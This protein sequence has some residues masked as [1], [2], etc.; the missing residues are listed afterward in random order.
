MKKVKNIMDDFDYNNPF[1]TNIPKNPIINLSKRAGIIR[2]TKELAFI[3]RDIAYAFFLESF[4]IK[5]C[6]VA[7]HN[8]RKTL[9]PEDVETVCSMENR[10][11]LIGLNNRSASRTKGLISHKR[12]TKSSKINPSSEEYNLS[13]I[14]IEN[15]VSDSS[16]NSPASLFDELSLQERLSYEQQLLQE[17]LNEECKKKKKKRPGTLALQQIKKL[18]RESDCLELPVSNFASVVK[19]ISSREIPDV[20]LRK[21]TSRLIQLATENWIYELFL[22]ADYLACH[23]KVQ[24]VTSKDVYLTLLLRGIITHMEWLDLTNNDSSDS[25]EI[26]S[27]ISDDRN[28]EE[29]FL[30]F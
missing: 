11:L 23:R 30:T 7:I 14:T 25:D 2:Q 28:S 17:Q 8:G 19:E 15:M 16:N 10:D 20:H 29:I 26:E 9:I 27:N 6:Y 4:I 18:Q 3:V 22:Y 5:I 13:N 21:G 12:R 24:T 1:S